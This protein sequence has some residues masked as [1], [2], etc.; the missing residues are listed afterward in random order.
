MSRGDNGKWLGQR[1][2]RD[3]AEFAETHREI[4]LDLLVKHGGGPHRLASKLNAAGIPTK[5]GGRW[6]STT[7]IRMLRYLGES[8]QQE[9][10]EAQARAVGARFRQMG[11]P[12]R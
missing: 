11:M 4:F 10:K 9:L 3:A 12:M 6:H 5:N 2:E 8:F 1:N 7:V